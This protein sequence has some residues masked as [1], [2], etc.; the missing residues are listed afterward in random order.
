MQKRGHDSSSLDLV[1]FRG[2]NTFDSSTS[3]ACFSQNN[4]KHSSGC[5]R[6]R[7]DAHLDCEVFD[8]TED[9]KTELVRIIPKLVDSDA[10]GV[11]AALCSIPVPVPADEATDEFMEDDDDSGVILLGEAKGNAN[12]AFPSVE[13][14][15]TNPDD[16]EVEED[17]AGVVFGELPLPKKPLLIE[18]LLLLVLVLPF[19]R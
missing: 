4:Q 19:L 6:V 11:I 16:D 12:L 18:V 14:E 2:M 15:N 8:V 5:L 17:R 3:R 13:T 1:S 9:D 7:R 10:E